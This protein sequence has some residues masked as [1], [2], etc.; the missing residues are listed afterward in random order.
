[1]AY[2]VLT[3]VLLGGRLLGMMVFGLE[4]VGRSCI[5][6]RRSWWRLGTA[7]FGLL[8]PVANSWMH[9]PAGFAMNERPVRSGRLVGDHLQSIFSVP[10]RPHGAGRVPDYGV[11]RRRGWAR[12]HLLRRQSRESA[13][14]AV[15]GDRMAAVVAPVQ[16][17]AGDHHGLSTFEYQPIKI[18]AMEAHFDDGTGSAF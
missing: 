12:V 17:V 1:M 15:H 3:R 11:C 16:A 9:T 7:L 5:S 18:A 2:E 10:A 8:D 13:R 14:R 4:H 6:S